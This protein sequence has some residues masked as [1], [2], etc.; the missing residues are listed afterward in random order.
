MLEIIVQILVF[1]GNQFG[2]DPDGNGIL[3]NQQGQNWHPHPHHH[4][5]GHHQPGFPSQQQPNFGNDNW[6]NNQWP[7]NNGGRPSNC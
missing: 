6:Q 1:L 2:L 7:L 4:W 5:P 3:G